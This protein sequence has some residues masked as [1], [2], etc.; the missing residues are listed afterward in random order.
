[1]IKNIK[2]TITN[3]L[4]LIAFYSFGAIGYH[5]LKHGKGSP[6]GIA[7]IFVMSTVI[8]VGI[9]LCCVSYKKHRIGR[10]NIDIFTTIYLFFVFML[11]FVV[12]NHINLQYIHI[13]GF[14]PYIAPLV[15]RLGENAIGIYELFLFP[16]VITCGLT[17][18]EHKQ[19]YYE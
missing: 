11:G 8:L 15:Y 16:S 7:M 10:F 17:I 19:K 12:P 3:L 6:F 2:L 4:L 18:G 13:T 1:M 9:I 14:F 5:C